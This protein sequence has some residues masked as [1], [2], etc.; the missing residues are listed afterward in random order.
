M[1]LMNINRML[2][3]QKLNISMLR[4]ARTKRTDPNL[5]ELM[6]IHYSHPKGFV[7]RNL[8]YAIYW[9]E[10]YFGHIVGGSATRFL[11]GRNEF[12]GIEIK[13]LN[14]VINNIFY[15]V[16]PVN[17]KFKSTSVNP[18]RVVV[19]MVLAD[20]KLAFACARV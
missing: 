13:D 18:D 8:C 1:R 6:K 12:L 3:L 7:G 4:L 16:F 2:L 5:L 9:N 14:R 20:I 11:P 15:H 19:K 17:N 10:E